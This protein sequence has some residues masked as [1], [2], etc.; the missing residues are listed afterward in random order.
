LTIRKRPG[1]PYFMLDAPDPRGGPR[2]RC[3]TKQTTKKAAQQ[4]AVDFL[5]GL[6]DAARMDR[7]GRTAV[8]LK[9][10]LGDYLKALGAAQ[11]P[12]YRNL[13][14]LCRKTLGDMPGRWS[15]DGE[16]WLHDLTT[17]D[18]ERLKVARAAEGAAAQTVAH[19]LKLLRA[20]ARYAKVLGHRVPDIDRWGLPKLPTKTR[21]LSWDEYQRVYAWL[22][23]DRM[24]Q[25]TRRGR[26][27]EAYSVKSPAERSDLQDAQDL[28]VTLC[29]TGGRWSE[30]AKLTWEQVDLQGGVIT[31]WGSKTAKER[32]VPI[33][34]DVMAVLQ[35]RWAER[36]P[37]AHLVFGGRVG[38]RVQPCRAISRAMEAVGLNRPDLVERSGRATLHSLRHTYASWLRQRGADLDVVSDML[39]HA[40]LT[41]TRRYAHLRRAEVLGQ[42]RGML[43]GPGG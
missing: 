39:G 14:A 38:L 5:A 34:K 1:S 7:D 12:S 23:P 15:L 21:Y 8:S 43:D 4:W 31:L 10:A 9:G 17:A 28:L 3:S 22:S 35:R 11:K 2:I 30:I 25:G 41:M 18:L 40:S 20:S 13:A 16:M 33:A 24:R 32:A 36:R 26:P 6:Q 29:L 27:M 37:G 19:E 42:V